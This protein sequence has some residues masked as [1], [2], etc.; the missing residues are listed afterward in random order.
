VRVGRFACCDICG[1]IGHT[2]SSC[3][4]RRLEEMK[5]PHGNRLR[6]LRDHSALDPAIR[7]A[8]NTTLFL[9]SPALSP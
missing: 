7:E 2:R 4:L 1:G 6:P 3:G 5:D 8:T 9:S